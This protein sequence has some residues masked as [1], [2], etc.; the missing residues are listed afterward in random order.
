MPFGVVQVGKGFR[1]EVSPRQGIIRL[2]EFS[3]AE[4]ELFFEPDNKTHPVF[5]R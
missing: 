3:M 4:A 2:R 5:M 1:N